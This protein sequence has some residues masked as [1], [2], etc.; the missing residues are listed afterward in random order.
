MV[1]QI[2]AHLVGAV[3]DAVRKFVG[4]RHQHQLGRFDAIRREHEQLAA[5][6]CAIAV[7]I[8]VMDRGNEPLVV[9]FDAVHHRLRNQ[10][11]ACLFSLFGVYHAVIHGGDRT[12]RHAIVVAATG[13]AGIVR[14]AVA[15]HWFGHHLESLRVEH[16]AKTLIHVRQRQLAHRI[17]LRTRRAEID[18]AAR[19]RHAQL[20]FSGEVP[21]FER[22]IRIRPVAAHAVQLLQL[23]I[24]RQQPPRS[25]SPVPSGAAH[26]PHILRIVGVVAFLDQVVVGGRILGMGRVRRRRIRRREV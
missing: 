23:E 21:G 2:A 25:R 20:H 19:T 3:A 7:R 5:H 11:R 8:L 9:G 26:E 14:T 4:G 12:D 13:W 22:F 16:V 24:G 17:G 10:L 15:G 6:A 18:R 1:H